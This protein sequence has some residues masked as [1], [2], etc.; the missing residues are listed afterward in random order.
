[1][2]PNTSMSR[3]GT[4]EGKFDHRLT[5]FLLMGVEVENHRKFPFQLLQSSNVEFEAVMVVHSDYEIATI[6]LRLEMP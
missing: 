5:L 6:T 2:I 1:M 3:T 4:N